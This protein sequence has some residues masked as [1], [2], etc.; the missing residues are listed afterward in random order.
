MKDLSALTVIIGQAFRK[1]SELKQIE[2]FCNKRIVHVRK[3]KANGRRVYNLLEGL[4]NNNVVVVC[5]SEKRIS[6]TV[7][8]AKEP[9]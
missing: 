9:R 6:G 5:E 4:K 1:K 8:P 3:E 2:G 7:A